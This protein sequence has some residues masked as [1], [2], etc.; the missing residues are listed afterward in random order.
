[1]SRGGKGR[2]DRPPSTS[3]SL[4]SITDRPP[5]KSRDDVWAGTQSSW[6]QGGG[7]SIGSPSTSHSLRSGTQSSR[8]QGPRWRA[9]DRA[10]GGG[11]HSHNGTQSSGC[12]VSGEFASATIRALGFGTV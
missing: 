3:H 7:P 2:S 1:M 9:G 11:E 10:R 12:Q 4:R 6:A 5:E 8:A